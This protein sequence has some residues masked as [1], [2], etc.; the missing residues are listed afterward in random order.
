MADY[1]FITLWHLDAPIERVYRLI[2][3][4]ERWPSWWRSVPAVERLP[5]DQSG[6]DR[7]RF[8]FKGRLPYL[9]RFDMVLTR[10]DPPH[11]LVGTATGE[12]DGI[13]EWTLREDGTGTE[14]RYEWRI[15]TTRA[16]MNALAPLPFV[17]AIFRLNHHAVMRDGL[18]GARRG[19]G[20]AG[21]YERL[22]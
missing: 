6:R 4:V 7:Y 17:D 18:A 3:D 21:S 16:W 10:K 13:G 19:L 2:E 12:L 9:V 22:A 11:A 14:A 20:V 8:T 15:K 5:L 1:S